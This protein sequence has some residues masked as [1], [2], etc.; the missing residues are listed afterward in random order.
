MPREERDSAAARCLLAAACLELCVAALGCSFDER[1]VAVVGLQSMAGG[2]GQG[3][4]CVD[5]SCLAVEPLGVGCD[6]RSELCTDAGTADV[7]G[8]AF[9]E[10][11]AGEERACVNS[12][13]DCARGTQR[14]GDGFTW[15]PCSIQPAAAD[16]CTPGSDANCD[17]VPNNPPGGCGACVPGA[18]EACQTHANLDG[19]GICRAGQRTCAA[20]ANASSGTWGACLGAVGPVAR[21]CSSE[22]DNDC[23]GVADQLDASCTCAVGATRSCGPAS[24]GGVQTCELSPDAGSSQF[25]VCTPSAVLF[26]DAALHA[27]V[28]QAVGSSVAPGLA[29]EGRL[30]AGMTTLAPRNAGIARLDGLQC[31]LS[32]TDLDL[33]NNPI[34]DVSLLVGLPALTSLS[35]ARTAL[36]PEDLSVLAGMTSLDSLYI[37]DLSLTDASVLRTMTQLRRLSLGNN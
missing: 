27:A 2:A 32:L 36:T 1:P 19:T 22:L 25:G 18:I 33:Y 5:G 16:T 30:I 28:R 34:T 20:P 23:N 17:G 12:L 13:G 15:G 11:A 24:C 29:I 10:C 31:A 21:N 37:T 14:C 35:V 26:P 7:A 9:G 8:E 4:A 3:G 6:G